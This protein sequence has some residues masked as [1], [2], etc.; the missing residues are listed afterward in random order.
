MMDH[1]IKIKNQDR[2]GLWLK[3]DFELGLG[4]RILWIGYNFV[5]RLT[6]I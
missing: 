6:L 2:I 5:I 1:P 4:L 3:L